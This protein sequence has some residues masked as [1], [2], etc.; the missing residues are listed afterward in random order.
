MPKRK[1][2]GNGSGRKRQSLVSRAKELRKR[3]AQNALVQRRRENHNQV[4]K[5]ATAATP[6]RPGR[7]HG[8]PPGATGTARPSNVLGQPDARKQI[9]GVRI[10]AAV[11]IGEANVDQAIPLQN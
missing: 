6:A 8:T 4:R 3:A 7:S 2:G 9:L 11:A 10:P 5:R 1:R